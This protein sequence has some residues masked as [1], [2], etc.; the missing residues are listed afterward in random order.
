MKAMLLAV[1]MN[2][3]RNA[4]EQTQAEQTDVIIGVRIETDADPT[5][6]AAGRGQVVISVEDS[7]P[8]DERK[9][10][11]MFT[12]VDAP[13][14]ARDQK[15]F[16]LGLPLCRAFMQAMSGSLDFCA[17]DGVGGRKAFQIS[18]PLALRS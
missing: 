7:A 15:H 18:L 17:A 13:P 12:V 8:I 4:L 6:T 5:G 16:G 2:L 9:V 14:G 10:A 11:T 3:V 1:V